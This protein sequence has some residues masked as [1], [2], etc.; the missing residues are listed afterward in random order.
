MAGVQ[1]GRAGARYGTRVPLGS[2]L[3]P[4]PVVTDSWRQPAP[5]PTWVVLDPYVDLEPEEPPTGAGES[6]AIVECAS[7]KAY[8]RGKH[9][10]EV[11][12]G[13]TL[14]QRLIETNPADSSI[15][16]LSTALYIQASD[17]AL[18]GI[19]AE[20]R[21]EFAADVQ[22]DLY[23]ADDER[24][25]AKGH[26]ESTEEDNLIVLT[27][28]LR[29]GS[30]RLVYYLVYDGSD[31]S[32]VMIPCPPYPHEAS[33]G[34]KPPLPV[35]RDDDGAYELLVL[36]QRRAPLPSPK[37]FES[38]LCL[39]T[40]DQAECGADPWRMLELNFPVVMGP[41]SSEVMFAFRG[42]AFFVDLSQGIL[43]LDLPGA[44]DISAGDFKFIP[45]P[46]SPH[47]SRFP[48]DYD[49]SV[50]DFTPL[51]E[52]PQSVIPAIPND[53]RWDNRNPEDNGPRN[54]NRTM[55]RVGDVV[56]FVCIDR[57]SM[58]VTVWTLEMPEEKWLPS[59]KKKWNEDKRFVWTDIDHLFR[60]CPQ[61]LPRTPPR[62]P[63][64]MPDG[65]LSLVLPYKRITESDPR[66]DCVCNLDLRGSKSLVYLVWWSSLLNYRL[67]YP[68]FVR[69]DFFKRLKSPRSRLR[70]SIFF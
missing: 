33:Y 54:I 34:T 70:G 18:R 43:Y 4:S 68:C 2:H 26:V 31:M 58:V 47:D 69:S 56:K 28:I 39:W 29:L 49:I 65:T 11:L 22:D 24:L 19:K 12:D 36:T 27:V 25:F 55:H 57:S 15:P 7:R 20:F 21:A 50:E 62:F 67:T 45:L 1:A 9:T 23:Q 30:F 41:F 14:H 6:W 60:F 38:I 46:E 5:L 48:S 42:K 63:I 51:P 44:D 8:G 53:L 64:L 17:G 3:L 16:H 10:Q 52:D 32:L 59:S 61:S 66:V 40:P 35:R 37:E 13:L